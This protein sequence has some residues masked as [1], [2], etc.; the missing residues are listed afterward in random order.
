[1]DLIRTYFWH[2]R[3]IGPS[4]WRLRNFLGLPLSPYFRVGNAGDIMATEIIKYLYGTSYR[5]IKDEGRRLL[6]VGSIAAKAREND[7]LCG[8]GVKDPEAPIKAAK[9]YIIRGLRGPLS[10]ERMKRV[11][12]DLSGLKFLLDPG[13]LLRFMVSDKAPEPNRV[14]FIP[15][16]RE[17]F[18]YLGGLPGRIEFVD[19]DNHPFQIAREILSA[20]LV[21]SSSLHGIIF[22]HALNRPCIFV[23]PQTF[24]PLF[25]YEDYFLSVDLPMPKPLD[26]INSFNFLR[27]S[28]TPCSVK[29]GREHFPFPSLEE[30]KSMNI[31]DLKV[32][33][34]S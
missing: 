18:K 3:V 34:T 27:D 4:E 8:V 21:Y 16:Y 26:S 6:C 30:L 19:I 15:H 25:K 20:K 9:D 31:V 2:D 22:S 13:L 12:A 23:S 33:Q 17:R 7:V 5:S 11:G 29:F 24:E 32:E 1:M 28:D 14:I 10:C